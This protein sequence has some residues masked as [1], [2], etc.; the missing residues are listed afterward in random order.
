MNGAFNFISRG[1]ESELCY[2]ALSM[3][4][5]YF[6]SFTWAVHHSLL[7]IYWACLSGWKWN[8]S[9]LAQNVNFA[10]DSDAVLCFTS[11][12]T[13]LTQDLWPYWELW[14]K[15]KPQFP[16]HLTVILGISSGISCTFFGAE[17]IL[18]L[19]E[20]NSISSRWCLKGLIAKPVLCLQPSDRC[21][22]STK[23]YA[24]SSA[25]PSWKLHIMLKF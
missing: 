9:I 19:N 10:V 21:L 23:S 4:L 2:T 6:C 14:F 5:L 3:A 7:F 15:V 22:R 20:D 16:L 12:L 13:V 18:P 25:I 24:C 1:C 8:F 17:L 11:H